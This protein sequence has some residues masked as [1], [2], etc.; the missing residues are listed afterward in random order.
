MQYFTE[1]AKKACIKTENY[2]VIIYLSVT[3]PH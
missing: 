2:T 1:N 3:Q